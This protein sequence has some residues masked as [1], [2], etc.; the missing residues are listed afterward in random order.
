MTTKDDGSP[1]QGFDC[2]AF[3]ERV[4]AEIYQE[5]KDLAPAQQADYFRKAAETGPFAE[6]WKKVREESAR[7]RAAKDAAA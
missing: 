5:I 4:Q 1:D 2:I 7:R 3:K 6:W